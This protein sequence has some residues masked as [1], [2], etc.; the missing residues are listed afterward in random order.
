MKMNEWMKMKG[1]EKYWMKS[2]AIQ[3]ISKFID[4]TLTHS[5]TSESNVRML[6][7]KKNEKEKRTKWKLYNQN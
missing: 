2:I 5:V 4:S 7:M 3:F 1:N 6:W